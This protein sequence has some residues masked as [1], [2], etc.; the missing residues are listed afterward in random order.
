MNTM[1]ASYLAPSLNLSPRRPA[2]G[3]DATVA[4]HSTAGSKSSL[5][6]K[7]KAQDYQVL[8]KELQQHHSHFQAARSALAASLLRMGE[9]HVRHGEYD[10]AASAFKDSLAENRTAGAPP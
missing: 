10:E 3:D 9:Y 5:G 4:T 7:A 1:F 2:T 8:L 6:S